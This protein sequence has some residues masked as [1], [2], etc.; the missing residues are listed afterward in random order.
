MTYLVAVW[1]SWLHWLESTFYPETGRWY[2]IGSS[3][4][5]ATAILSGAFVVYKQ[6]NCK[7]HWWCPCWAHHKVDGT[8]AVVCHWHHTESAHRKLQARHKR[9]YPGRLAHGQSTDPETGEVVGTPPKAPPPTLGYATG[10]N[11][12]PGRTI[13]DPGGW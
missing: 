6:H 8:T 4:A 13:K 2:A 9:K 1:P 10:G 12:L 5:G 11:P 3:W 7:A